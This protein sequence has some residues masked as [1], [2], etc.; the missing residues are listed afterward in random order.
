MTDNRSGIIHAIHSGG[1]FI[2]ALI[3]EGNHPGIETTG[4]YRS[5]SPK[6]SARGPWSKEK[7]YDRA[8]YHFREAFQTKNNPCSII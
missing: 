3:K 5:V 4:I 2:N 6:K 1:H 7:D 8:K